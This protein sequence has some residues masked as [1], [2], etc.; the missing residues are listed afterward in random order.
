METGN[1]VYPGLDYYDCDD[2]DDDLLFLSGLDF[3]LFLF[4]CLFVDF[5]PNR[6]KIFVIIL[7][8]V[9]PCPADRLLPSAEFC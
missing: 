2:N 6:N 9:N 8:T 1:T 7:A 3:S 5:M 4:V